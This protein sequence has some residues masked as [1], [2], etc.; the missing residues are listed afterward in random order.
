M[1]DLEFEQRSS[2]SR[3]EA[4]DQVSALAE[5]LLQGGNA[6]L[7]LGTGTISLRV[8]T[9]SVPGSKSG[10]ATGRSRWRSSSSGPPAR[11]AFNGRAWARVVRGAT[12][13]QTARRADGRDGYSGFVQ[14]GSPSRGRSLRKRSTSS[15]YSRSRSR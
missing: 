15:A 13:A 4:A 8:P 12:I 10:A 1:K 7:E 2:L 9:S 3:L 6:E 14:N 11:I 5:A